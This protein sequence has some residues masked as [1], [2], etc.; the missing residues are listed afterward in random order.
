MYEIIVF[1]GPWCSACEMYKHS[2]NLAGISFSIV[3][4]EDQPAITMQYNI[5]S[6]PTTIILQNKEVIARFDQAISPQRILNII[7]EGEKNYA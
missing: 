1:S 6:L 7:S 5:K 4:V 3:D 2:L